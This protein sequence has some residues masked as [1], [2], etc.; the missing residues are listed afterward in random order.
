MFLLLLAAVP[1]YL[2]FG[3]MRP[4]WF[5]CVLHALIGLFQEHTPV[6]S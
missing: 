2:I 4:A 3:E 6:E 5:V 1:R